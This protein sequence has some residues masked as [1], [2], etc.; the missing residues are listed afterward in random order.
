MGC[1]VVEQNLYS[2][3]GRLIVD[4]LYSYTLVS[5]VLILTKHTSV[6]TFGAIKYTACHRNMD[7][8]IVDKLYLYTKASHVL[9]FV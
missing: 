1:E 2:N 5:Y 4:K 7:R 9:V 8:I 3:T 6:F